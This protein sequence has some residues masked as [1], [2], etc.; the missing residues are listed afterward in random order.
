MTSFLFTFFKFALVGLFNSI[1]DT[2]LWKLI[3]NWILTRPQLMAWLEK[4]KLNAYSGAQILS[5]I[6]ALTSS[7]FMNSTFTWAKSPFES[8]ARALSYLIV[9]LIT[10]TVTVFYINL[11]T[12]QKL[13]NTINPYFEKINSNLNFGPKFSKILDYP[14]MVKISS[15]ALSMIINFVGYQFFVFAN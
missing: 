12:N 14:L 7:F 10:W 6:V 4:R 8:G 5:F 2:T 15:I 13:T 9:S 1:L 3:S 11:L